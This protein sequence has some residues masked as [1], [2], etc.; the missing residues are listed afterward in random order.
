MYNKDAFVTHNIPQDAFE[1][2]LILTELKKHT[3]LN[4][5]FITEL[6]KI[7]YSCSKNN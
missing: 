5:N 3:E 6:K 2:N 1:I 7:C 4:S